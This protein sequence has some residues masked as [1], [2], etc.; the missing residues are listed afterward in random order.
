MAVSDSV[1]AF[2]KEQDKIIKDARE[3]CIYVCSEAQNHCATYASMKVYV[4]STGD[5]TAIKNFDRTLNSVRSDIAR[6]AYSR[7]ILNKNCSES[8]KNTSCFQAAT[9]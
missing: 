8:L 5:Y 1:K 7:Y 9:C 6:K 4:N 3:H 2:V